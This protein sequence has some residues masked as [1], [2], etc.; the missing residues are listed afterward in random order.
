MDR[1]RDYQYYS[2]RAREERHM[3]GVSEDNAVALAHF[4][5]AD[6]YDQRVLDMEM[7]GLSVPV[8]HTLGAFTRPG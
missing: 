2:R 6:A 5:M 4:R 3:A 7:S 1:N 8:V